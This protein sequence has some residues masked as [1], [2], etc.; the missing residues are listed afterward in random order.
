MMGIV[1]QKCTEMMLLSRSG[2]C[3]VVL[4]RR[5]KELKSVNR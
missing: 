2:E 1:T 3:Q 5:L 4:G